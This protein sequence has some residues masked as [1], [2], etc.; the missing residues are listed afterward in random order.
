MS[1]PAK[2][3]DLHTFKVTECVQDAQ[4]HN[5][6]K[7][8]Y[9]HDYKK[10]RRRPLGT[11]SSEMCSYLVSNSPSKSSSSGKKC[12]IGD[13]CDRAHNR[14]EEFYH[15]DKYKAKFCSSFLIRGKQCDY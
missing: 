5:L 10:D 6:K 7:C 4:N 15:P 1:H 12:P 2:F 14:V 11:Y 3:L 13:G 9:Y 8:P